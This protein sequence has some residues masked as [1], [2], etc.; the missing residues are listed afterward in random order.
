[1]RSRRICWFLVSLGIV[2]L[3]TLL[4]SRTKQLTAGFW[5]VELVGGCAIDYHASA[6]ALALACPPF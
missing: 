3:A 4:V 1:M 5:T 2:L 6:G